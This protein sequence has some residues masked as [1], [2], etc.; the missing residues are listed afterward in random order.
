MFLYEAALCAGPFSYFNEDFIWYEE[1]DIQKLETILTKQPYHIYNWY[2]DRIDI[3]T[4]NDEAVLYIM[5]ADEPQGTYS[6]KSEAALQRMNELI[7]DI[8]ES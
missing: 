8:G 1:D 3:Y 6:A 7:G 2:S 4:L 5:M